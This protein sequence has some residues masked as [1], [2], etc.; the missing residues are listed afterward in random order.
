M[1]LSELHKQFAI[2]GVAASSTLKHRSAIV[3][4]IDQASDD[5][6]FF[7]VFEAGVSTLETDEWLVG[8]I[9]TYVARFGDDRQNFP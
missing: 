1:M 8:A 2:K 7:D 9:E 3:G 6:D 5:D 4:L